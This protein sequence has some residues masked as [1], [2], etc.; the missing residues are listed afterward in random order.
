MVTLP[1]IVKK[2]ETERLWQVIRKVV[3]KM[4]ENKEK[5]NVCYSRHLFWLLSKTV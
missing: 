3:K 5:R 4:K 2:R 1:Y